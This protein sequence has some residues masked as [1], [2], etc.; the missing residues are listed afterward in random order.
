MNEAWYIWRIDGTPMRMLKCCDRIL[1]HHIV[2]T[3]HRRFPD[4]RY[5]V[6]AANRSPRTLQTK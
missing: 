4:E 6:F 2:R 1:A 3:W 5:A